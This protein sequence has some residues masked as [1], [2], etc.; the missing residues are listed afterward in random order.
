MT[1][2]DHLINSLKNIAENH[3]NDGSV[4]LSLKVFL[5]KITLSGL[6][7]TFGVV[8][9]VFL[10][11][12]NAQVNEAM[13]TLYLG[14]AILF[15]SMSFLWSAWKHKETTTEI[16]ESLK[17]LPKKMKDGKNVKLPSGT[18]GTDVAHEI[19]HKQ[20]GDKEI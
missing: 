18:A 2:L 6:A 8:S 9:A 20:E 15:I 5:A 10:S 17:N 16:Y 12:S 19:M 1:F 7:P 3:N 11:I 14:V 13:R 4:I